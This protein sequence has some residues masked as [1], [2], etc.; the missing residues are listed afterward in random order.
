MQ[1]CARVHEVGGGAPRERVCLVS[2]SYIHVSEHQHVCLHLRAGVCRHWAEP[3]SLRASGRKGRTR[4]GHSVTWARF[5]VKWMILPGGCSVSCCAPSNSPHPRSELKTSD[6][7]PTSSV[8]DT[9]GAGERDGPRGQ[10]QGQSTLASWCPSQRRAEGQG[11]GYQE[12]VLIRAAL[13]STRPPAGALGSAL[14]HALGARRVLSHAGPPLGE[15]RGRR[16]RPAPVPS[17]DRAE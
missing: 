13:A 10:G 3:P 4:P 15:S 11:M 1:E 16:D 2:A 14:L 5:A 7:T 6:H 8:T 17:Q 9:V 12:L